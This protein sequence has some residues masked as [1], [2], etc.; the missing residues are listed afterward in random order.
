MGDKN[1]DT[2]A[3]PR[4]FNAEELGKSLKEVA[5]DVIATTGDQKVISRWF[6]SSKDADLFIWLD[7][8]QNV[9]KQQLTFFGQVVEWNV[10]EGVKTGMIVEEEATAKIKASEI[11]QF[12]LSPQKAPIEQARALLGCMTALKEDER[13]LLVTNFT[14]I[15]LKHAIDP[16]E[17]VDRFGAFLARRPEAKKPSLWAR[18]L[19]IF[20]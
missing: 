19:S 10:I 9:I 18:F 7:H 15:A 5:T 1:G 17:F 4:F 8:R 20:K 2:P 16:Q 3:F 11:V 14:G 13:T 12:D 6:H